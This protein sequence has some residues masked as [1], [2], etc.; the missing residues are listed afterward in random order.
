MIGNRNYRSGDLVTPEN[1]AKA[2]ADHLAG[3]DFED[4]DGSA[5]VRARI[6][7]NA[8]EMREALAAFG[9]KIDEG[10][11]AAALF[12]FAGHGHRREDDQNYLDPIVLDAQR[13][14]EKNDAISL[15]EIASQVGRASHAKII[16]ID[17]CRDEKG[18]SEIGLP[19]V[20]EISYGLPP[21][22]DLSVVAPPSQEVK[23]AH[24]VFIGYAAAPG[25]QADNGPTAKGLSPFT[26]ALV[27]N[28]GKTGRA[29]LIDDF[30]RVQSDFENSSTHDHQE[31][32]FHDT[33][34][35]G[36]AEFVFKI[37]P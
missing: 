26:D 6:N 22:P 27:S 18:L 15:F 4:I 3:H 23:Q 16:L 9:N 21:R 35:S 29:T 11:F 1:D 36:A 25:Q 30:M 2:M 32:S 20:V 17:A 5:E 10:G 33:A 19:A 8:Q 14:D 37:E 34:G 7:L 24:N 28:L 13:E 12:Y 31:P